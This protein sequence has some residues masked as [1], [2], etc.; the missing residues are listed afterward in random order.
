MGRFLF[1]VVVLALAWWG[2]ES[3]YV[4]EASAQPVDIGG[5]EIDESEDTSSGSADEAGQVSGLEERAQAAGL[6]ASSSL[7][8]GLEK[9][10]P[11][12]I[13]GGFSELASLDPTRR[14]RLA[15]ALLELDRKRES[16]EEG[17]LLLG[18][19]NAFLRTGEGRG[20]AK[21]VLRGALAMEPGDAIGMTSRIL[22]LCM[23]GPL[24][25]AG[26]EFV[27]STYD[28]HLALVNQVEFNPASAANARQ[29]SVKSGDSLALIA[30]RYR[31]SSVRLES[32]TL[33]LINR[34]KNANAIQVGQR[35]RIPLGEIQTIVEKQSYLLAIYVGEHMVRLYPCAHGKVESPTPVTTFM[36][37]DKIPKP[38]WDRPGQ[39][40]AYG[41][42]AN[43]LGTHFVK[44]E[45]AA[46]LSGFGIHGTW[47]P[48]SIGTMASMGCV[49]LRNEDVAEFSRFVPRGT[50]VVIR[51][52][53]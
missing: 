42:P 5:L 20:V 30:K 32:G 39:R 44:F 31:K 4:T 28:Q 48:K 47:D 16:V 33:Q 49:R 12:A 11:E 27:W 24:D 45:P 1:A 17:V 14:G 3:F 9:G 8:A 7:I 21:G 10:D 13:A 53:E 2:Y 34:I 38:D 26:Q 46:A 6:G 36:I 15:A 29:Y 19:N 52:S 51:A 25:S 23:R 40:I 50:K 43:P 37:K 41:D 35:L 22:G 18:R